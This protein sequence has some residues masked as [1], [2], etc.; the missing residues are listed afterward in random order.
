LHL[1]VRLLRST[2]P[3]GDACDKVAHGRLFTQ[4]ECDGL[5]LAWGVQ[6]HCAYSLTVPLTR[7]KWQT[8]NYV[9]ASQPS[10]NRTLISSYMC[11]F[12]VCTY[13][14]VVLVLLTHRTVF[15]ASRSCLR[16]VSDATVLYSTKQ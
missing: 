16:I 4:A 15:N 6:M 3:I 12:Q 13:V 10:L 1:A 9:H 2:S 14:Y 5:G 11:C 7:A 8:H